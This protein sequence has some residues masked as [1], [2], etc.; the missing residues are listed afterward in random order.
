MANTQ[1]FRA[2]TGAP[3]TNSVNAAGGVAYAL[4][5]KLALAQYAA[6]GCLS[7]TFYAGADQQLSAVL[8][9]CAAVDAEFIAKTAV[10]S[11]ERG[12]MKDMPA[13]LTAILASRDGGL[14]ERIFDRV[15]DNGRQLRNFVQIM[16]SGT[17]G[18]R[19]LGSRPKR[20]IEHWLDRR[21]DRAIFRASIGKDPSLA[22]IIKMVHPKPATAERRALYG[23]LLARPYNVAALPACVAAYEAY[24]A[25]PSGTI[26][27]VPF[28]LL[29][30]LPLSART[31]RSI[32][33]NASWQ[34][35]RM[36]LNTFARHGVFGDASMIRRIAERLE[37]PAAVRRAKVFP[38]QL[39]VAASR[40]DREVPT[41]V[42]EAL[43][44]AMEHALHNVPELP[45]QIYIFPDISGSMHSPATGYRKGATSVLR[46]IDIAALVSA[47]LLR[48]NP[49]ALVL[50]F[51]NRVSGCQL[52]ADASVMANA[53][54]LASLPSGGTQCAVP[55]RKLN[56][57]KAT[58]DLVIYI[59][60]NESWID[61]QRP[62][63]SG[64]GVMEEWARFQKR[65][66]Q[67]KMICIDIQPNA[68]T[69]APERPD[70]IN[71]GGFSDA[72][73]QHIAAFARDEL[74]A[75]RWLQIIEHTTL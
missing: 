49:S 12:L 20:M 61:G 3:A 73:F 67:A 62:R 29:T 47:A 28:Q 18:R 26:P 14:C 57:R 15:I 54:I 23:Y 30:G 37:D 74:S 34:M 7:N 65:S 33:E 41:R 43:N 66:P 58:G 69:Q 35:T 2:P 39:M 70:I 9:L 8:D 38:Y 10:Y 36:N 45:G 52:D 68:T 25:D 6:T 64:T 50:P 40:V 46:C 42:K 48:V 19:S 4:P 24:K 56:Q 71:I 60:D 31:W 59:S 72:V 63:W 53:Q 51:S 21:S 11:R 5:A 22:D 17:T 55:L 1:L 13:L 44:T 75:L 32:A 16:R 27:D